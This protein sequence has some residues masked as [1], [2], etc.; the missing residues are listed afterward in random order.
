MFSSNLTSHRHCICT[1][2]HTYFILDHN[3]LACRVGQR[4]TH[5]RNLSLRSNS[6][7]GQTVL[8]IHD[9]SSSSSF[10]CIYHLSASLI[11]VPAAM[12]RY[13]PSCC[14][15]NAPCLERFGATRI[16]NSTAAS[17]SEHLVMLPSQFSVKID[18]R[19]SFPCSEAGPRYV[20]RG[21][22]P[23]GLLQQLGQ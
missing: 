19:A 21:V 10:S 13:Y 23:R 12:L 14:G 4:L 22:A 1:S 3:Y 7:L 9:P 20:V 17:L 11:L 5:R 8:H 16:L 2:M 15:V 18:L 6:N